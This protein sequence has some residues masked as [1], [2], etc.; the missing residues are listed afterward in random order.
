MP[1]PPLSGCYC[2]FRAL[3]ARGTPPWPAWG[4]KLG[5]RTATR[6]SLDHRICDS[7]RFGRTLQAIVPSG[8]TYH[9]EDATNFSCPRSSG[10][11]IDPNDPRPYPLHPPYH[12]DPIRLGPPTSLFSLRTAH[13]IQYYRPPSALV[14]SDFAHVHLGRVGER[15]RSETVQ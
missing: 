5:H 13:G 7:D 3:R 1:S 10:D 14:C 15:G 9:F 8:Q 11:P 2:S 6:T 4:Q 12:S